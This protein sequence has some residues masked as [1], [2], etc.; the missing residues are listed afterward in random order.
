MKTLLKNLAFAVLPA[1]SLLF[2][3]SGPVYAADEVR[4]ITGKTPSEIG[5]GISI[6]SPGDTVTFIGSNVLPTDEYLAFTIPAGVTLVWQAHL[7]GSFSGLSTALVS[8]VGLGNF[9][10]A[11][12]SIVVT[13]GY[14][15]AIT[16]NNDGL[17]EITG[18]S[19]TAN[20]PGNFALRLLTGTTIIVGGSV[21]APM[22]AVRVEG[23]SHFAYLEGIVD[24][25]KVSAGV[26]SVHFRIDTLAIPV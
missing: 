24:P 3:F 4:D 12:G 23:Q 19:V 25:T 13:S 8:F 21:S 15:H 1:L 6:L 18:G 20:E 17:L 22:S 5:G 14:S 26:N 7:S 11:G 16:K 9:R 2:M 10:V